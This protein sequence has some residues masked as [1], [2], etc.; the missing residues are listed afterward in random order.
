M[1]GWIL[2][3]ISTHNNTKLGLYIAQIV[4]IYA[5]PPIYAAMEYNVLGR[6]MYYLPMYTPLHPGRAL[7][8]FIYLG[9]AVESLTGSGAGRI[10]SSTPGDAK[11][12]SG[13]ILIASALVLQ[14]A[15]EIVYMCIVA[16]IQ[17][18]CSKAGT[19]PRNIKLLC[20]TLYGTSTLVLLR[21]IFRAVEAFSI[22]VP[23]CIEGCGSI[24]NNEWYLYVFEATPMVVYTFWLNIMHPGR[25]L[26]RE[27]HRYLDLDGKTE[28]MGPGWVDERSRWK[29]FMDP[30]NLKKDPQAGQ[31]FWLRPEE[32]PVCEDGSFAIGTASNR[33]KVAV[34]VER[35]ELRRAG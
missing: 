34:D 26:P 4:F 9:S 27:N 22:Y 1:T 5:G 24:A 11:Y 2:R 15:V 28:R 14:G 25:F 6:L 30:F 33:K 35:V 7:I 3:A 13:G 31:K 32:W 8:F 17:Y 19:Q 10:A 12:K 21:C 18:R 23:D 16:L 29:T 20:I